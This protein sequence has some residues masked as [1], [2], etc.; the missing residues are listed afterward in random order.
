MNEKDFCR[1]VNWYPV[2]G[3]HSAVTVFMKLSQQEVKLLASGIAKGPE[4]KNVVNRLKKIMRNN[5][6]SH[7]FIST[8]YCSPT[9]TERF[10]AKHG[11]VHS[12]ESAWFYLASS[13]KVREEAKLNQ[14]EY[15]AIRPF[16]KIDHTRE[17][18]LFIKDGELKAMSQYNLVR[19]Y[20]RLEGGKKRFWRNTVKWFESV[21]PL[22]PVKDIVI[23]CYI[24]SNDRTVRVIDVNSWGGDTDPLLLQTFDR[25]WSETVGIKLML[26]P[27]KI[28]GDVAVSF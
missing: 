6:F 19:H 9:D 12:A 2:L 27:T 15:L 28:S 16:L 17:F 7:S 11:A 14:I 13:Q 25:D 10:A 23:D 1:V 22:L 21:K 4:V 24:E 18:R 3:E 20:R 8:D 5:N 26:P